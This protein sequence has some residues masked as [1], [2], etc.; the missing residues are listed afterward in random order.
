[1]QVTLNIPDELVG[2]GDDP[3][4]LA[5]EALA[6]EG[7]RAG[8]LSESAL[9]RILGFESRMQVHDFLNRNGAYLRY[10]L[11]DLEKDVETSE[12]FLAKRK[13]KGEAG[14]TARE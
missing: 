14:K 13:G 8:R 2:P 3:A 1:M 9:R 11:S 6:L 12:K 10:D 5:L 4:R 7:Y